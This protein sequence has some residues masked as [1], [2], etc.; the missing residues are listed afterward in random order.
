MPTDIAFFVIHQQVQTNPSLPRIMDKSNRRA[1]L[2]RQSPE[3]L[4]HLA[5]RSLDHKS[6][7]TLYNDI[8]S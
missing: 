7:N 6:K 4:R 2:R 3:Q 5:L 1:N 8:F